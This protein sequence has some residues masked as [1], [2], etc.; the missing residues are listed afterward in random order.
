MTSFHNF[1]NLQ[2]NAFDIV[3]SQNSK[4]KYLEQYLTIFPNLDD[5]NG[6]D[7][8]RYKESTQPLITIANNNDFS[9]MNE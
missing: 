2:K 7:Y 8:L 6:F 1:F 9:F 4:N 3:K 5:A